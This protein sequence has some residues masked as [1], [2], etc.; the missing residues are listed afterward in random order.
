MVWWQ[1]SNLS[2]QFLFRSNDVGHSK[3]LAGAR[4][5]KKWNP[6]MK[7]EG[8]E[9]FVGGS[10]EH[11]FT[12]EFWSGLDLCWNALDNVKA[13]KYTDGRCLWYAKPLLESGTT[14][15][16]SNHEVILPYRTSTY[17]DGI[18]PPEEG[19][20]MC[21]LK[22]FPY[23]PLHCIEFAK[24][25]MFSETFEFGPEQYE[26]Y[27]SNKKGFFEQMKDNGVRN[28][29]DH[30]VRSFRVSSVRI[31]VTLNRFRMRDRGAWSSK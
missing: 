27:R 23:L 29:I 16:M 9:Q 22:S 5:V 24:Q 26:A 15:T 7:V 28:R 21:T 13:R 12:D 25:K 1:V 17:N 19:I 10:T 18:E 31:W 2:R 6:L 20:A 30:R 8:V 11:V 3:S 4:V 14:G